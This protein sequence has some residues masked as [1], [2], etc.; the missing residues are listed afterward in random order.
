[1]KRKQVIALLIAAS[2]AAGTIGNG[3]LTLPVFAANKGVKEDK[4]NKEEKEE[5][6]YVF[7][8]ANGNTKKITVSNWLK[9]KDGSASIE[10]L[11]S[12]MDI[13]N[14]KGDEDFTESTDG[15]LVWDAEGND[16]FYQG[17]TDK[18]TPVS[19]SI[20]YYLDGQEISPEELAGKAGHVKIRIDYTKKKKKGDVYVPFTALTGMVFSDEKQERKPNYCNQSGYDQIDGTSH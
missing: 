12:L 13:E 6:V 3:C 17:S 2:M 14:V 5:T 20:H 1:M 11:T 10:D 9:N 18:E 4:S 15:T 19:L 8:D 16:I 7:A